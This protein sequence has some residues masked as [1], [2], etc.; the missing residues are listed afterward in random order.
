MIATILEIMIN[1]W[2]RSMLLEGHKSGINKISFRLIPIE[3]TLG[4]QTHIQNCTRSGISKA[5]D[6]GAVTEPHI[7]PMTIGFFVIHKVPVTTVVG[8]DLFDVMA[9]PRPHHVIRDRMTVG[10]FGQFQEWNPARQGIRVVT[11]IAG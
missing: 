1:R 4:W 5:V 10:A 3:A 9:K 6:Q 8:I 7:E 2:A 11:G